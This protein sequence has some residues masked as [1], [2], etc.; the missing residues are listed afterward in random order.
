MTQFSFHKPLAFTALLFAAG[1]SQATLTVYTSLAA[2]NAATSAQ[3]TDTFAGL[4]TTLPTTSPITRSVGPYSYKATASTSSFFAGGTVGDPFLSTSLAADSI[5]FN[6]FTSTVRGI[7]GNFFGSDINGVYKLGDVIVTATD[8]SGTVTQTIS[9]ASLTSF[10]GFV[11][12]GPLTSMTLA[13]VTSEAAPLWP[14]ADNLVLAQ[15]VVV[16]EPGTYALWFA[17]LGAV[18]LIVRRRR[19]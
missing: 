9:G 2:F 8:A 15:A 6:T 19:A 16:P 7:G 1:A 4:S 13:S 10:L 11:S 18:G 5:L 12:T 14:S 17:G 3:G